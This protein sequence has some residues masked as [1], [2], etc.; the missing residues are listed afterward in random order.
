MQYLM[1]ILTSVMMGTFMAMMVPRAMVSA[2]RIGEVLDTEP[3]VHDAAGQDPAPVPGAPAV[4]FR[5]VA[6][7]YPGAEKD[8]VHGLDFVAEAGKTTAIIGS[9]GSGKTTLLNLIPRL[10]D[11][12]QGEVLIQGVPTSQLSRAR[13]AASV[14]AV[15]Q[16]PFLFSGTVATNLRFGDE[17]A[18]DEALW[19]ALRVAQADDFVSDR[20]GG[21][22]SGVSQGGTNVS[23]GQRQRL[24]IARALVA[25]PDVYLFDDSFSALD[26]ATDARLRAALKPY[27]EDAAVILVAQRVSTITEADQIL[28]LDHGEIVARGTHDQLL[29]NSET[30]QEI[31]RSQIS[32]EEVA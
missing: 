31:V 2:T 17:D 30:Y 14:S 20:D 7:G 18:S 28:V 24:C 29:E 5:G 3:T 27:T 26:V 12:D 6:F 32:A 8:V 22:D 19:E 1:Q 23:G 4:E 15:P 10:Y 13:L 21:L 11:P 16:K 9:T 25:R